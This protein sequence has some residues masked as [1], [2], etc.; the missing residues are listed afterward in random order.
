M[1]KKIIYLISGILA[2]LVLVGF[3]TESEPQ[4]LFG[5]SVNI[6]V[7]RVAWLFLAY[8]FL[9]NYMKLKREEKKS[10]L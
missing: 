1:N 10:S 5:I 6:W 8:F 4:D 7:F 9:S 3:M 2:F